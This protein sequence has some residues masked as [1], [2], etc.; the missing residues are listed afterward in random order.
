MSRAL[1]VSNATVPTSEDALPPAPR[2]LMLMTVPAATSPVAVQLQTF[3]SEA[4]LVPFHALSVKWMTVPALT[5]EN[6]TKARLSSPSALK[7]VKAIEPAVSASV[8]V[9]LLFA[10]L[11]VDGDFRN[12]RGQI[13]GKSGPRRRAEIPIFGKFTSYH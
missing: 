6:E 7:P 8:M 2:P 13:F 1:A 12:S 3:S 10:V 9:V 5:S 11:P 4:K